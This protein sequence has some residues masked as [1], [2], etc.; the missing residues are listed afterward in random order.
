MERYVP[1]FTGRVDGFLAKS[2][3]HRSQRAAFPHWAPCKVDTS[4]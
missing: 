4:H 3:P 2:A 1:P